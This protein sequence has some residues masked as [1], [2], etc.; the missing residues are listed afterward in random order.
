MESRK[1]VGLIADDGCIKGFIMAGLISDNRQNNFFI[2]D[3]KTS[4]EILEQNFKELI[5]RKD[6]AI[7]FVADFV[8][9]KI[10]FL[11]KNFKEVV[12][13]IMTIPTKEGN[14]DEQK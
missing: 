3:K 13:T 2:V 6:I 5:N 14:F 10:K 12:P 7:V 1:K 8:A 4:E 11:L 9:K